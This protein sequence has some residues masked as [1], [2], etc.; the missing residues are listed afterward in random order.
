MM[1]ESTDIFCDGAGSDEEIEWLAVEDFATPQLNKSA[2]QLVMPD[3]SYRNMFKTLC[4]TGNETSQELFQHSHQC[5]ICCCDG[6]AIVLACGHAACF[7]CCRNWTRSKMNDNQLPA[8]LH[9]GCTQS[10]GM[11]ALLVSVD[12]QRAIP[13]NLKLKL[14]RASAPSGTSVAQCHECQGYLSG[15]VHWSM[16]GCQDCHIKDQMTRISSQEQCQECGFRWHPFVGCTEARLLDGFEEYYLGLERRLAA[17]LQ[18]PAFLQQ[19]QFRELAAEVQ[20]EVDQARR[21]VQ[22]KAARVRKRDDL[23]R[24]G[25]LEWRLQATARAQRPPAHG[26]TQDSELQGKMHALEI[27]EASEVTTQLVVRACPNPA[28]GHV[29]ER[30]SGCD[31]MRCA[32]CKVHFCWR[33]GEARGKGLCCTESLRVADQQQVI[34]A[35]AEVAPVRVRHTRARELRTELGQLVEPDLARLQE[36]LQDLRARLEPIYTK[37][38]AREVLS[39]LERLLWRCQTGSEHTALASSCTYEHGLRT[40]QSIVPLIKLATGMASCEGAIALDRVL[41][42]KQNITAYSQARAIERQAC[43]ILGSA[44]VVILCAPHDTQPQTEQHQKELLVLATRMLYNHLIALGDS[45]NLINGKLKQ[46]PDTEESVT[47]PNHKATPEDAR[48]LFETLLHHADAVAICIRSVAAFLC[49][50]S[51]DTLLWDLERLKSAGQFEF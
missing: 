46:E 39:D 40:A 9:D 7:T 37:A 25:R 51:A 17:Q 8:C 31:T 50:V 49:Q 38:E 21:L 34:Q 20:A 14:L 27:E 10:F 1:D 35:R 47:T 41:I 26:V 6:S 44:A 32:V 30:V 22:D 36:R 42:T 29:I 3:S 19:Q 28:C 23:E 2:K 12:M 11:R 48:Q 45:L 13:D 18:T 4:K 15:Q 33:C 16:L 43:S 5:S 24:R